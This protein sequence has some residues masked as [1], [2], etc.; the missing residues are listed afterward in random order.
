MAYRYRFVVNLPVNW[1]TRPGV[2]DTSWSTDTTLPALVGAGCSS[3][4]SFLNFPL[5]LRLVAFAYR[6]ALHVGG[7]ICCRRDGIIPCRAISFSFRN[8]TWPHCWWYRRSS[9][10]LVVG[11]LSSSSS[12]TTDD[13]G[14]CPLKLNWIAVGVGSAVDSVSCC[15]RTG[16]CVYLNHICVCLCHGTV[17][18]LSSSLSSSSLTKVMFVGC[19]VVLS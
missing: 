1:A 10:A 9:A 4:K 7:S 2:G 15:M 11:C 16:S 19:V 12:M 14:W 18:G 8:D 6:Q 3:W 13:V 5:H 17:I